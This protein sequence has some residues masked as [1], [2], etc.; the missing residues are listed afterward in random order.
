MRAFVPL[1]ISGEPVGLFQIRRQSLKLRCGAQHRHMSH[2]VGRASLDFEE[3]RNSDF[4]VQ[5]DGHPQGVTREY[6][7][8]KNPCGAEEGVAIASDDLDRTQTPQVRFEGVIQ[9]NKAGWFA[10]EQ[11]SATAETAGV[12]LTL[13][14]ETAATLG[15]G[16]D[17]Y[18]Q[19]S[20]RGRPRRSCNVMRPNELRIGCKRETKCPFVLEPRALVGCMC[21]LV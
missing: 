14:T 13:T 5:M 3:A 10:S 21:G 16:P 17:G 18:H 12:A 8:G 11:G 4:A 2:A 7:V 20:Q 19:V 1:L 15:A 9:G 6:Q